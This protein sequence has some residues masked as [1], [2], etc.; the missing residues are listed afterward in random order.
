LAFFHQ[1]RNRPGGPNLLSFGGQR[2]GIFDD[3]S[4]PM[5]ADALPR[6][7]KPMIDIDIFIEYMPLFELH[8]PPD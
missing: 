5:A 2:A 4:K 6:I 8:C 3:F 1:R 7:N